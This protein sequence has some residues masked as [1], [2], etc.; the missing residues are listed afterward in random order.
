MVMSWYF[1][2]NV[3]EDEVVV[4]YYFRCY[5]VTFISLRNPKTVLIAININII[6]T[7]TLTS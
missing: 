4:C 7:N 6:I 2:V 5:V 1:S 3:L